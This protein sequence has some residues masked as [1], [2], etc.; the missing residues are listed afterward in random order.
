MKINYILLKSI[1]KLVQMT[2]LY[3]IIYLSIY[4]YSNIM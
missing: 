2:E 1:K 4:L 3:L